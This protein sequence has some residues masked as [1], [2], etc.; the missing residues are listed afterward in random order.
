MKRSHVWKK[1]GVALLA[2]S[3]LVLTSCSGGTDNGG[4]AP[5]GGGDIGDGVLRIGTSTEVVNWVPM[6][7]VSITDMWVMSQMYPTL[8]TLTTD[9]Q[10]EPHLADSIELSEDGKTLTIALNPDFKWSDGEPITAE[11]VQ[12]TFERIRDDNLIG[13]SSYIGNYDST[14]IVDEHT[15]AV[16]LK[17]PSYGWAIDVSQNFS[18]MPKHVFEDVPNLQEYTLETDEERWVSGGAWTLDRVVAGQRYTFVPNE[19]YPLRADGNDVVTGLEFNIYGDINTMQLALQNNDID[20]MAP[21][22]PASALGNLEQQSNIEIATSETA[23]NYTKLTFNSAPGKFFEDPEIREAVSGLIDTEAIIGAVLQGNGVQGTSP[24]IPALTEYQPDVQQHE[25]DAEEVKAL[26]ADKGVTNANIVLTCDQ[27]N[28]NHAKSAQLVRDMLAPADINVDIK[29]AER[30][31]SLAAAKAG[32]FDLYIHKLNQQNSASSNLFLQFEPSNPSGLNYNFTE[33][34][35]SA[36]LIAAAQS[37]TTQEEYVDAVKAAATHIHEQAYMVP[38]YV[39]N[40]N[41]AY[42]ASRFTGYQPT[43]ME[44][45]TMVNGWSLAQVVQN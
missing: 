39:E 45:S 35:T 24:V 28:A 14:E 4:D 34:D 40:L 20:I 23:L 13:G 31:T 26:L 16:K 32:E 44:T 10:F 27:G 7:S 36:Q 43:G 30:A 22:V 18:V 17:N 21:V 15:A 19:N 9:G 38:L 1:A 3:A 37:A 29:C 25:S 2:A 41:T 5:S 8:Q 12:F 42:N 11:D 33:D 6:N